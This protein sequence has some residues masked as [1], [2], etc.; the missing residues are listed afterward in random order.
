MESPA[1][2]FQ[3]AEF[4]ASTPISAK[5]VERQNVSVDLQNV[6]LHSKGLMSIELNCQ[7]WIPQKPSVSYDIGNVNILTITGFV[8]TILYIQRWE[9]CH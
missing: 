6:S 7:R 5:Q 4:V 9:V 2:E 1:K 8:I 3:A